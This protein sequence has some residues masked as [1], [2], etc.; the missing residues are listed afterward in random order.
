MLPTYSALLSIETRVTSAL[1]TLKSGIGAK[2]LA[3][4]LL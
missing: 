3:V 4:P 1:G 2:S